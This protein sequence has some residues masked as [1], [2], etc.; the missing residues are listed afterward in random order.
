MNILLTH[1]ILWIHVLGFS[2][3]LSKP[4]ATPTTSGSDC[5]PRACIYQRD[6]GATN[7]QQG[8]VGGGELCW[9]QEFDTRDFESPGDQI[10][11]VGTAWGGSS[12]PGNAV[13]NGTRASVYIWDELDD[14]SDPRTGA[15]LLVFEGEIS[16]ANVDT[17]IVNYVDLQALVD[18][19]K[20]FYVGVSV[21]NATAFFPAPGDGGHVENCPTGWLTGSATQG[22]F[23]PVDIHAPSN[24]DLYNSGSY[25]LTRAVGV[26]NPGS[27]F[28]GGDGSGNACPCGNESSDTVY[29]GCSN[30]TGLGGTLTLTG[31][32]AI[33]SDDLV[34]IGSNLISGQ[35][36][37]LFVGLEALANGHGV[38]FGDGLRCV[39]TQ[40]TRLGLKLPDSLGRALWG[41]GLQP[42]GHWFP[43]DTRWFQSWYR[44][45]IAGPCGSGFNLTNGVEVEFGT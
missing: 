26:S 40:V 35:T 13:P 43:G 20:V 27:F 5:D 29:G 30:S 32:A 34:L 24:Y 2:V 44:D 37:L 28:C 21:S 9:M 22:G 45:P 12:F 38:P 10:T 7:S 6:Y 33:G 8:T 15:M 42:N 17:D 36:A 4:A 41:P 39:G 14:D 18:V 16:V 3:P 31:T 25:Y 1:L 23:D 11:H 19:D